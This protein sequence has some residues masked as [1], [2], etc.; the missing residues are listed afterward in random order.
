L[1]ALTIIPI[2]K[3]RTRPEGR[4]FNINPYRRFK[5]WAAVPEGTTAR[6]FAGFIRFV[7]PVACV[8]SY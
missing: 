5:K 8:T 7:L 4:F 2:T 3:K 1:I 6:L